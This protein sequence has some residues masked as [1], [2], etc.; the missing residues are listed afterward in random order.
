MIIFIYLIVISDP[1]MVLYVQSCACAVTATHLVMGELARSMSKAKKSHGDHKEIEHGLE[2]TLG[3]LPISSNILKY[4]PGKT[5]G[6]ISMFVSPVLTNIERFSCIPAIVFPGLWHLWNVNILH[7]YTSSCYLIQSFEPMWFGQFCEYSP[8][9]VLQFDF[10]VAKPHIHQHRI[11]SVYVTIVFEYEARF[12]WSWYSY[13]ITYSW[14]F[15][16]NFLGWL[17]DPFK[18]LSDLQL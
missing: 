6:A 3:G 16:V 8:A 13:Q 2:N 5:Y 11:P 10:W 9:V 7:N 4:R 15:K 18:G 14:W 12:P 17:S 1:W